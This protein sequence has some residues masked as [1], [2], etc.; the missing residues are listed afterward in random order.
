MGKAVSGCSRASSAS[1][2]NPKE[3]LVPTGR[4]FLIP[5]NPKMYTRS[6]RQV[7]IKEWVALDIR[8]IAADELHRYAE[9][10]MWLTVDSVYSV[11]Q[12]P[13]P[14]ASWRLREVPVEPYRKHYDLEANGEARPLRWGNQFD[15]RHWAF[16][17]A[18]KDGRPAGAAAVAFRSPGLELLEGRDDLAVLWDL[19]VE[20][21]LRRRGV[22]A[23]LFQRSANWAREQG[24]TQLRIETQNVN[25]PACRFY[26]RMGCHL[27]A[28]NRGAYPALPDE[29]QLLWH[30]DL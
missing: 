12:D 6:S 8:Q 17:L 4:S 2:Q 29:I 14:S 5:A 9:I 23:T 15:L 11:E 26:K 13:R 30:F 22:G 25:V 21:A 18:T 10:P 16:F 7:R 28:A 1:P 27:V 19:R 3:R 20:P 24:C